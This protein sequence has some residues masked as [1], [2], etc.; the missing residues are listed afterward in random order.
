[1]KKC[2]SICID[3]KLKDK[4]SR[5]SEQDVFTNDVTPLSFKDSKL[6]KIV[7]KPIKMCKDIDMR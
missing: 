6:K 1:M 3:N 7:C 2:K 5:S 4:V